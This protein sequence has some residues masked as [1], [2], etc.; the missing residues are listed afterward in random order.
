MSDTH[1]TDAGAGEGT[2]PSR[3]VST[4]EGGGRGR[5]VGAGRPPG[6]A[7]ADGPPSNGGESPAGSAAAAAAG[8]AT[9]AAA[10]AGPQTCPAKGCNVVLPDGVRSKRGYEHLARAHV[11]G[12][13]D[14]PPAAAALYGVAGCRW[15][16]RAYRSARGPRGRSSL[17][18]HEALCRGNPRRQRSRA[19]PAPA[20]AGAATPAE[21]AADA[22]DLFA[23][24]HSAWVATRS[25]FL[26]RVAPA[27]ADWA[28]LVASGARTA[29][30]VPSALLGAWR[31]LAADALDW[32]RREPEHARA[33]LWLLLLPTL[34]LH[35]PARAPADAPDRPRPPLLHAERA[36][37]VMRGDFIA[38]LADRNAGV[39]RPGWRRPVGERP[40]VARRAGQRVAQPS[41]SQ[42]RA[43][44]L[45]REGR[46]SAAARAL[47]AEPP[48]PQT[49]AIW[50]KAR[51]LFPPASS[52]SATTATVEAEFAAE[53]AAAA[54]FGDRPLVPRRVSRDA[55]VA[56]IRS[57]P[58]G[59]APGPSGLRSEHLWA[60]SAAGQDALVG[61]VD[62][63]VGEAL[64]SRL[65]AVAAHALAGADLL[66]LTKPGGVGGDGLPGL[67]PIGM[68]ET[69]RKLAASALAATVRV[70]AAEL[71]SPA[72][73]GVG[74][75]SACERL[76][77]EMEAHLAYHPGHA[78]V[79]LDY[80]NAFNLVSRA[81]A[82]AVLSRALPVVAPLLAT[83]YDGEAA[84]A[85]YAWA[86]TD[87]DGDVTPP[88]VDA[89]DAD[90]NGEDRLP[91]PPPTRLR[92]PAE[93][94]AQQGD[95]LGPLLHAAALW[96]VLR[97]L[98]AA[99]PGAL[100]RA[101]H[102]DVV[103]LGP[104][105]VLGAVM[106]DA[107]SVGAAVDADLAPTKCV[108]WSP[109]GAPAPAGW[110][111][112]WAAEGV[113]QFSVPLGGADF[114][115]AG[116]NAVAAEHRELVTAIAALPPTELQAQLLLLRL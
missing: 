58:R 34:L 39:W 60:L 10:D 26:Q 4:S 98:R 108:G 12:E 43:L 64:A 68:P 84:P 114:V 112:G 22:A 46:L 62:L 71:L 45:V 28:P 76:L 57:A 36:A 85:V 104:P 56:A 11:V 8:S 44:R 100:I 1:G 77:H 89:D 29:K 19:A 69:L 20:A 40:A 16:Q 18:A 101:F 49:T 63:L 30:H 107:A 53:L 37:V 66:L 94:G 95:P 75:S 78:V 50:D 87:V 3:T 91:P 14:L 61:V 51:G 24:D 41:S 48:A 7:A 31:V 73:L 15:C 33:W 70:A 115:S 81:A 9:P 88:L 99:H 96:L 55:V 38:A 25:A 74:V 113:V 54:D 116:V 42:R 80:R 93:R 103:A 5:P 52:A 97:R 32:V 83:L 106:A 90:A 67:R 109:A 111:G 2:V 27:D 21:D 102:D 105:A 72:Q 13:E 59:A 110:T 35:S 86:A 23:A 47:R 17:S 65:P 82:M 6:G 79:Q 92:L